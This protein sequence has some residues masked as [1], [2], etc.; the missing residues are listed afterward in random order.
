MTDNLKPFFS[1]LLLSLSSSPSLPFPPLLCFS[2]Q[3]CR[4]VIHKDR[5]LQRRVNVCSFTKCIL[6]Y[7]TQKQTT[8]LGPWQ[9]GCD[10][11]ERLRHTSLELHSPLVLKVSTQ[12]SQDLPWEAEV[13]RPGPHRRKTDP[14]E[15]L[16]RPGPRPR[17]LD[18]LPLLCHSIFSVCHCIS[19]SCVDE[20]CCGVGGII[21]L[22]EGGGAFLIFS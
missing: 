20:L 5:Q 10:G 4:D 22:L 9:D 1:Q 17:L 6:Q 8:T 19:S 11:L 7:N 3:E 18:L 13:R 14:L 2:H 16:R 21:L 15:G 12:H